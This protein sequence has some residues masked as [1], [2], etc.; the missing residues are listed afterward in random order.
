[1]SKRSS[2]KNIS[3]KIQRKLKN[4]NKIREELSSGKTGQEVLEMSDLEMLELYVGAKALFDHQKYLDSANAFLFLVTLNPQNHQYWMGLGT[5]LQMCGEVDG[6][7]QA[8]EM[9]SLLQINDPTPY[10]YLAKCLLEMKDREATLQALDIAIESCSDH[11]EF[12]EL[13][14]QAIEAKELLTGDA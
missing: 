7:L 9:A 8:Y 12:Q 14:Q 5:G 11:L 4:L 3:T 6:A 1:M 13:K 10:F 2:S